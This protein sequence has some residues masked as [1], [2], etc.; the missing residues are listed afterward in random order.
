MSNGE[1]VSKDIY[2]IISGTDRADSHTRKVARLYL[3]IFQSKGIHPDFLSLENFNP[4]VR[5]ENFKEMEKRMLLPAT[6]F[7]FIIPE[8]NGSYPGVLKAMIDRTDP[9]KIWY[10]KKAL[11]TGVST[12]RAGNLR[13]MDHLADTLNFMR[14]TVY[15]DKL[16]ISG[17]D[18]LLTAQGDLDGATMKVIHQQIDGFIKF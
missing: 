2:T 12:G 7:V 16:P 10:Y 17:V 15:Y 11:L 6:K 8:Y 18:K 13:G 14:M 4:L 1:I 3:N 5:D 9:K